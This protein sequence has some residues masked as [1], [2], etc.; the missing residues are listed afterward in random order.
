[1][2][3]KMEGKKE[4]IYFTLSLPLINKHAFSIFFFTFSP[5]SATT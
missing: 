3:K 2:K 1:M 4:K 5:S